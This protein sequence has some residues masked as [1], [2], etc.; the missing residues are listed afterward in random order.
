MNPGPR[1]AAVYWR[2]RLVLVALVIAGVWLALR[3]TTGDTSAPDP[4]A[5]TAPAPPPA[6]VPT[7]GAFEVALNS[8]DRAC[9]PQQ[10]RITP[11]VP[12]DQRAGSSVDIALVVSTSQ[13]G[14]CTLQPSDA[15]VIAVISA[16]DTPVWDS[17][18]CTTSLLTDPVQ[19]AGGG[20]ATVARTTWSGR[21][22]GGGCGDG[23]DFV[24]GGRYTVQLG[25]LGGEPG[26][27][28]F[29]LGARPEPK[30]KPSP[31]ATASPKKSN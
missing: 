7:N 1:R 18:R 9:D 20:W 24:G 22:S 4:T 30:P 15:D 8:D 11:T 25:T 10:V 26:E 17:T 2:R 21:R 16:G 23:E 12:V 6:A 19:L 3:L 29:T 14:P 13:K 27:A 31:S 28:G 5:T